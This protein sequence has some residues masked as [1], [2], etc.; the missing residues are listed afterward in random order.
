MTQQR[1]L[2][3]N[4]NNSIPLV[5]PL[6]LDYLCEDLKMNDIQ[7]QI[8]DLNLVDDEPQAIIQCL[9]EFKPQ[10]VG[11]TLR[12]I[13]NQFMPMSEFYLDRY[14]SLVSYTKAWTPALIVLGGVGFSSAPIAC[15]KYLN[16]DCGIVGSGLELFPKLIKKFVSETEILKHPS[17][18]VKGSLSFIAYT[19]TA[20]YYEQFHPSRTY[21]DN[22]FYFKKGGCIGLETKMGC[23]LNCVYC[24]E[25]SAKGKKQIF[26]KPQG[27]VDEVTA[28]FEQ[29]ITVF[30]FNDS[31]FNLPHWHAE[32]VCE[33]LIA[34]DLSKKIKWYAYCYPKRKFIQ[35]SLLSLMQKAGCVGVC[36]GVDTFD[37]EMLKRLNRH[38]TDQDV[39]EIANDCHDLGLP[40]KMDL[41]AGIPGETKQTLR[42][43]INSLKQLKPRS[44]SINL[45]V[46]IYPYTEFYDFCE[47]DENK[48]HLMGEFNVELPGLMPRWYSSNELGE[49]PNEYIAMLTG[50]HGDIIVPSKEQ[51][52]TKKKTIIEL[53][54]EN[55]KGVFW[56]L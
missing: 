21:V 43:S 26:R 17:I 6:A 20:E 28:L 51:K 55:K 50:K 47:K 12:N 30:H 41:I 31:E 14:K 35:K 56:D 52:K 9:E 48:L 29:G 11:I 2:F 34:S 4:P 49:N 22:K 54:D 19:P 23:P 37:N 24:V 1:V 42:H 39:R 36:F 33:A 8:L 16:A 13:C 27:I 5:A 15:L 53:L 45:G 25:P 18:V 32:K 7:S 44:A 10:I 40:F 46:R 3:I 38:Y